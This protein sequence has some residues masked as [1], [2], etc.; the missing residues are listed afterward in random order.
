MMDWNTVQTHWTAYVP[1]LMSRFPTLDETTLLATDGD[2]TPVARQVAATQDIDT[3]AARDMLHEW[4]SGAEP[5]D[6][7]MDE[8]RDNARITAS[9][10][11]IPAGEDVYADDDK[12]G[13]DVGPATPVGRT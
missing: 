5:T 7:M 4:A 6:A 11:D 13:A 3:A 8:T 1:R 9:A 12:F 10:R 2:I